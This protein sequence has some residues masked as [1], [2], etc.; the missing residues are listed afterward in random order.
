MIWVR[1]T[2]ESIPIRHP[3]TTIILPISYHL[4]VVM[5]RQ[6]KYRFLIFSVDAIA[7]MQLPLISLAGLGG[8]G[9]GAATRLQASVLV[10]APQLPVPTGPVD[11]IEQ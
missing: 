1:Q 9:E 3:D 7:H 2:P 6:M 10:Q 4:W 8:Y 5:V 11:D